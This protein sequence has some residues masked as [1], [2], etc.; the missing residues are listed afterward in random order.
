LKIKQDKMNIDLENERLKTSWDCFPAEHLATYLR[1]GEQDQR[2]NTHSI[3][4][5]ALLIDTLWPGKFDTLIDEE[6]RFGVVMT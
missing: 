6:L 2:I 4:T 3:L 5:R 1:I